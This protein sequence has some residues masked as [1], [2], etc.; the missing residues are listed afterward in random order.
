MRRIH[1][2]QEAYERELEKFNI[3]RAPLGQDR[4][5]RRY[6]WGAAGQRGA[7]YVEDEQGCWAVLRTRADLDALMAALDKR[8]VREL[9]LHGALEKVGVLV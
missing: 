4:H 5:F 7:L 2:Q 8:G 9:A 3:R 6:W 1:R